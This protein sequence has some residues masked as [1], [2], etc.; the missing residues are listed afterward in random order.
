[1]VNKE[2]T[3]KVQKAVD[4]AI[5]EPDKAG[6]QV[7][8]YHRGALVVDVWGGTAD[9]AK[10]TRVGHDTVFWLAA[11]TKAPLA[12]ALHI[13]AERGLVD[14]E[15]RIAQ[16]WP[17]FGV[18][19]KESGTVYD[20]LTHRLGIPMFPWNATPERMCDWDWVVS[21]IA[22][23]RPFWPPG[24]TRAYHAYPFGWIM[25]EIVR[26]TDP[27]RRSVAQFIREEICQPLHVTGLW[28][29]IPDEVEPRVATLSKNAPGTPVFDAMTSPD[30]VPAWPP[31]VAPTLVFERPDVRRSCTGYGAI[32]DA[33]SLAKVFALMANGGELDGV[34]LLSPDQVHLCAVPSAPAW[35]MRLGRFG[36]RRSI[37]GFDLPE[38]SK[39]PYGNTPGGFG[40][41]TNVVYA[42]AWADPK[43]NLAVAILSSVQGRLD[44]RLPG[45]RL[46]ESGLGAIGE[47][48]RQAFSTA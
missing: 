6:M 30:R 42:A 34:R 36:D 27:K 17:E 12:L 35:D 13:Q 26:R 19:G 21:A 29:G 2:A 45:S 38:G 7:A 11:L 33:R 14:Y 10:G 39:G 40:L 31:Q 32:G 15:E 18:G 44:R 16:Y 28:F 4:N 41:G 24:T 48:A 46:F 9:P 47:V 23:M 3:K 8:V 37:G 1:M 25:G 5:P 43:R 20:A 22:Q